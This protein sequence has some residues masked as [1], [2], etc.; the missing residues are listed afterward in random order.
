M[1]HPLHHHQPLHC[2]LH[3]H[4]LH[5]Q[6]LMSSALIVMELMTPAIVVFNLSDVHS[7]LP[8]ALFRGKSKCSWDGT[9]LQYR[10]FSAF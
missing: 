9:F 1:F 8:V 6:H 4:Y 5:Q 10:A 7:L 2:K 3:P